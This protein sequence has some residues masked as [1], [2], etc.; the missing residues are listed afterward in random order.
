M[1]T[2]DRRSYS[3]IERVTWRNREFRSLSRNGRD[4]WLYLLTCPHQTK[5]P[6]LIPISRA[7][8]ADDLNWQSDEQRFSNGCETS[9]AL[10]E[11][12]EV[13]WV[14]YDEPG[15]VL[16]IPNAIHHNVPENANVVRGWYRDIVDIPDSPLATEWMLGAYAVVSSLPTS[17]K[18]AGQDRLE[19]FLSLFGDPRGRNSETVSKPT[20]N[21][22]ETNAEPFRDRFETNAEPFRDRFETNA[23]PFRNRSET[24]AEPLRNQ[25]ET[26]AKPFRNQEQ[27]QKQEQKQEQEQEQR[28]SPEPRSKVDNEH[29]VDT[30]HR[31]VPHSQIGFLNKRQEEIFHALQK[32]WWQPLDD[33]V[34]FSISEVLCHPRYKAV[35]ITSDEG[36]ISRASDDD[37]M[38]GTYRM[39]PHQ[40]GPSLR[41][42][43][44][45]EIRNQER[46]KKTPLL[47]TRDDPNQPSV[48]L[49]RIVR[50]DIPTEG[51]ELAD[52]V[53]ACVED[54]GGIPPTVEQF[55]TALEQ[56]DLVERTHLGKIAGWSWQGRASPSELR[57]GLELEER[58]EAEDIERMV[59]SITNGKGIGA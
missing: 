32:R 39:Q 57:R 40:V 15:R 8:I 23:E 49:Q 31:D 43:A 16:L 24:N 7:V 28:G 35:D 51:Q 13:G 55:I 11:L 52:L 50:E 4:L 37:R 58:L 21:R 19:T 36:I 17:E 18:G 27:E 22:L 12:Q 9:A 20:P 59:A 48:R 46:D 10:D 33:G 56:H 54:L 41:R 38:R 30:E 1:K 2:K 42:W 14:K 6:G 45:N 34:A 53:A 47:K 25:R 3:K 26:L 5:C 29:V 44:D